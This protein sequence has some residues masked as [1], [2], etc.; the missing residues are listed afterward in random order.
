MEI[1]SISNTSH[2]FKAGQQVGGNLSLVVVQRKPQLIEEVRGF[3]Q[4]FSIQGGVDVSVLF[5]IEPFID[6]WMNSVIER[7]V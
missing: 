4:W 1:C 2:F 5:D 7:K 3:P 6:N